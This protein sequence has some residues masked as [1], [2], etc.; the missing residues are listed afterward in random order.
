MKGRKWPGKGVQ[1][2]PGGGAGG[3]FGAGPDPGGLAE[4]VFK[5]GLLCCLFSLLPGL[6]SASPVQFRS[7]ILDGEL[8][9]AYQ[10]AA[11]DL[12]EDG[13]LDLVV[14]ASGLGD[15]VWYESP[16]WRRRVL[17]SGRSRMI[18]LAVRPAE[19]GR[20][21]VLVLAE[22]F[23]NDPSRSSGRVSVLERVEASASL[24]IREIDR[25]PT[26]HRLRWADLW[27][28]GRKVVVN[29]P[30]AGEQARPPEYRAPVSLVFYRPGSW[31]REVISQEI[32]GVLHGLTIA[33]WDGDGREEIWTA[34]F[35]G[36]HRFSWREGRW[37]S[38]RVAE[39]NPDLW[40]LS[41]ASE[42]A[43]IHS[44]SEWRLGSIEPW[45]GHQV[46]VYRQQA[47]RW[48]RQVID[49]TLVDGH[50]LLAADLDG[51]GRDE[52]VAGHR[53]GGGGVKIYWPEGDFSWLIQVLD[54]GI[55][56]A[57]CTAGDL[58]GDGRLDLACVGSATANLKWYENLGRNPQSLSP[59]GSQQSEVR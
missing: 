6:L 55:A 15:L 19:Q 57:G 47:G 59:R 7:H 5:G 46:V 29:A 4:R 31:R 35:L 56:A 16:T 50:V 51:D 49:D 32:E 27:G 1:N 20:P 58:N 13:W 45:H 40:P 34:S 26:S 17:V 9:G 41:G 36:I 14:V 3:A 33:D 23:S 54:Q 2:W 53:G 44:G 12:N 48:Q 52:I 11:A 30:L 39:G 38:R 28:D 24:R 22:E 43:L 10:V 25:L 18:N 8:P 37:E 42:V 21:A